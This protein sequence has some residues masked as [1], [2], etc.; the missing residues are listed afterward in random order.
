MQ[1]KPPSSSSL[2][3]MR[4]NNAPTYPGA[5]GDPIA[6]TA[7]KEDGT[8]LEGSTFGDW[9][10]LAA[11]GSNIVTLKR[12]SGTFYYAMEPGST[13]YAAPHVSGAAALLWAQALTLS[14]PSIRARLLAAADTRA[15][16]NNTVYQNKFLNAYNGLVLPKAT[17]G[18]TLTSSAC[19]WTGDTCT[20]TYDG[21]QKTFTATTDPPG[22][23]YTITHNGSTTVPTNAGTYTVV[24]TINTNPYYQGS[25][26]K[27]LVIGKADATVSIDNIPSPGAAVVGGNFTP[28]FT[29]L[30]DG[31]ASVASTTPGT[32][33][34]T[35]VW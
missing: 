25:V 21:N 27:T 22:I 13:S 17:A 4:D 16:L 11:P 18:I 10:D 33:T 12:V 20:T 1:Q 14:A 34:V 23:P 31:S 35:A 19:T 15:S 6:V 30:G 9:V 7:S 26:S 3:E 32:C 28:T 5:Y 24:A 8:L 2:L 29:K